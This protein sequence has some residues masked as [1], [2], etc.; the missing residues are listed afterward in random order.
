M[1]SGGAAGIFA[2]DVSRALSGKWH[3]SRQFEACW[4]GSLV[5]DSVVVVVV[6]GVDFLVLVGL[7]QSVVW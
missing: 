6:V 2:A 1:G 5:D 3:K 4:K 7:W